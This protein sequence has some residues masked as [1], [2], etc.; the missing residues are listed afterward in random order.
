MLCAVS[1]ESSL[2]CQGMQELKQ[3]HR[4][5]LEQISIDIQTITLRTRK[6]LTQITN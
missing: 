3:R 6:W 2:R 5:R 4:R 1:A